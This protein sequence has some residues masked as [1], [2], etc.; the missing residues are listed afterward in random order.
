MS[1]GAP[2]LCTVSFPDESPRPSS[3]STLLGLSSHGAFG[4]AE[5]VA[6]T[7]TIIARPGTLFFN[8][9]RRTGTRRHHQVEECNKI[10]TSERAPEYRDE[11]K[12]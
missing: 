8:P 7:A 12:Q 1:T 6:V 4:A 11:Q 3:P 5:F 9:D 2:E 10:N